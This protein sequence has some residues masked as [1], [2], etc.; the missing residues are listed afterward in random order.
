[1]ATD[2]KPCPHCGTIPEITT[3]DLEPQNDG[4][5][6]GRTETFV[7]CKCGLCLFDGYFHEGFGD[8]EYGRNAAIEAW[9]RRAAEAPATALGAGICPSCGAVLAL[10]ATHVCPIAARGPTREDASQ[11]WFFAHDTPENCERWKRQMMTPYADLTEA[12]KA[13]DRKVVRECWPAGKG[14]SDGH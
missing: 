14:E 2:L 11:P 1:M 7:L 5:Y 12:E 8:G 3:R 4:W 9:N 10:G 6:S 13:S